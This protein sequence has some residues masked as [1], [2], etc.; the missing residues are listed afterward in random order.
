MTL[1][2]D[3]ASSQD[4][5]G[6]AS[7]SINGTDDVCTFEINPDNSDVTRICE[8]NALTLEGDNQVTVGLNGEGTFLY[9]V[10]GVYYLPWELVSDS[11]D[12]PLSI[13]VTYD[14]T[15]LAV[16]D[17][18]TVNVTVSYNVPGETAS[19]IMVDLGIP[20]GFDLVTE[21]LAALVSDVSSITRYEIRG[22]QLSIYLDELAHG[23]PLSFSY[24]MRARFPIHGQ[25]PESKV[26]AYYNPETQA[27]SKPVTLQVN[28]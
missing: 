10:V 20:P 1:A 9:Q 18:V 26:W 23:S 24:G 25:T 6:M 15:D 3:F 13:E 14:R 19:M 7:V 16:D 11:P 17:T 5:N 22:R 21:D 8:L 2:M 27:V 4:V 28:P 12:G